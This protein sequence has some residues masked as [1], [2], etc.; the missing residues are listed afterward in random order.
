VTRLYAAIAL[1][2]ALL[3]GGWYLHHVGYNAG[4]N[5]AIAAYTAKA[6]KVAAEQSAKAV[7]ADTGAKAATDTGHV[8]IAANTAQTQVVT[9]T[10]TRIV[11]DTPSPAACVLP[12]DSVRALQDAADSANLA[13]QGVVR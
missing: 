10:I 11:H 9:R 7:Q 2:L 4:Q 5:D 1:C 6:D 13:A 3:A 12:P 8:T